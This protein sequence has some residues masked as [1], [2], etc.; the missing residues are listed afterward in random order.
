[1]LARL[2]VGVA[3]VALVAWPERHVPATKWHAHYD[4]N[5]T[6]EVG[7]GP[8]RMGWGMYFTADDPADLAEDPTSRVY[9]LVGCRAAVREKLLVLCPEEPP[10]Y[11]EM[12]VERIVHHGRYRY[13]DAGLRVLIDIIRDVID[14]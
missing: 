7:V 1:M 8:W 9:G 10:D 3:L 13:R 5:G 6:A 14:G 2:F 4:S 11:V 12:L